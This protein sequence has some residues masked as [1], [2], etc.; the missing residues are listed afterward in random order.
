MYNIKFTSPNNWMD[1]NKEEIDK[2]IQ[3]FKIK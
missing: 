1:N 3:S 2:I